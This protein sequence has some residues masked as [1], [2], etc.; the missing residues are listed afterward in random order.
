[1]L[2]MASRCI[3]EAGV[4]VGSCALGSDGH[5]TGEH[6]ARRL[7]SGPPLGRA[8]RPVVC[9]VRLPVWHCTEAGK[10]VCSWSPKREHNSVPSGTA[11]YLASNVSPRA[12][13][14]GATA[15][16]H[17]YRGR[18]GT[19]TVRR[20]TGGTSPACHSV[21][22]TTMTGEFNFVRSS[23]CEA[24]ACVQACACGRCA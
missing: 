1:M 16:Q 19:G 17:R 5:R 23:A 4:S 8:T 11:R 9:R 18:A 20:P 3:Y 15:C 12:A 21:G 22:A 14:T 6:P 2:Y 10:P 24:S 13:A 7:A